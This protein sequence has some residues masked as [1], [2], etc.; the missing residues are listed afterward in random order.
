MNRGTQ[1]ALMKQVSRFF[2]ITLGSIIVGILCLVAFLVWNNPSIQRART[3]WEYDKAALEGAM[4]G[5]G[6]PPRQ[7]A[8]GTGHFTLK[9]LP[10]IQ[11][12]VPREHLDFMPTDPNGEVD[13]LGL[14]FY[15][16]DMTSTQALQ[17]SGTYKARYP[18]QVMVFMYP[19]ANYIRCWGDHCLGHEFALFQSRIDYFQQKPQLNKETPLF[20]ILSLQNGQYDPA[21]KLVMYKG[22]EESN[23]GFDKMYLPP[24][25]DPRNPKE[26]IHCTGYACHQHWFRDGMKIEILFKR[27]L[28]FKHA[29][30]RAKVDQKINE[31]MEKA[32]G[33][34]S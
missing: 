17:K 7:Q 20:P 10:G 12:H 8:T 25:A 18:F 33:C 9:N 27:Y 13:M 4:L 15:L 34:E 29:E 31:Y 23:M 19:V 6:I 28:L 2:I 3:Q 16:P 14:T 30:I 24:K 21:L 5:L 22:I 26:W 11:F 1:G 32:V